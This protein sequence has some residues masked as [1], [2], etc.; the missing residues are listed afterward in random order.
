VWLLHWSVTRSP[1]LKPLVSG[2]PPPIEQ[3]IEPTV[4]ELLPIALI[5]PAAA[6]TLAVTFDSMEDVLLLV[7]TADDELETDPLPDD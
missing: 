4:I 2:E 1:T 3:P 7:L 5:G 6:T